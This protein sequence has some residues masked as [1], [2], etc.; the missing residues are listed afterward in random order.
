[1]RVTGHFPFSAAIVVAAGLALAAAPSVAASATCHAASGPQTTPLV[2]LFTSEGCDSC[3]PADRWL[4]AQFPPRSS[5]TPVRDGAIA[6]AYH[7]DYWDRL[8]WRDR[9]AS[10]QF[11]Q[12][13]YDEMGANGA[14]FVYTPQVLVQGHAVPDWKSGKAAEAIAVALRRTPRAVVSLDVTLASGGPK[15]AAT[16]TVADPSLRKRA[17]LWLAFVDS[18]HVTDV[19]AGEN[20]GMRLRHDNVVRSLH[21]PYPVD[22]NGTAS[23]SLTLA[24]PAIQGTAPTIVAYVQD[25]RNG[26]VLQALTARDCRDP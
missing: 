3:P 1:M 20:R 23:A 5:S 8:G 24:L 10:A 25:T 15:V 26:D 13:Q 4:S 19:A 12:R 18:G 22:G 16:A 6:L 2:E 14:A 7:V 17:V 21:G 9:F 11:T